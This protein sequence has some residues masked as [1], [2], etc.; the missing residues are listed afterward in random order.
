MD[1]QF[2]SGY[3]RVQDG[4]RTVTA[5]WEDGKWIADCSYGNCPYEGSCQ[6]AQ[7]LRQLEES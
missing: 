6:I 4:A 1:E 7:R 5:E 3:C 2:V